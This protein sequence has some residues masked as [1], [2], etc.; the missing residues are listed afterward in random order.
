[1]SLIT[2]RPRISKK[3]GAKRSQVRQKSEVPAPEVV[4]EEH[5]GAPDVIKNLQTQLESE[6][7]A[8]KETI[9]TLNNK[10]EE[11]QKRLDLA[12]EI[13]KQHLRR[14]TFLDQQCNDNDLNRSILLQEIKRLRR[15]HPNGC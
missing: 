2:H 12:D 6:R 1:M 15:L 8:F 13:A 11:L 3:S 14:L 7:K 9:W 10:I 5:C 4:Q